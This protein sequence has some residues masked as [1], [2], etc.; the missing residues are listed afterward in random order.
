MKKKLLLYFVLLACGINSQTY[1]WAM[2]ETNDRSGGIDIAYDAQGNIFVSEL[3]SFYEHIAINKYD[4]DHNFLW[5]KTILSRQK[6]MEGGKIAADP[7]GNCYVTINCWDTIWIS[8]TMYYPPG[9]ASYGASYMIKYDP[10]GMVQWVKRITIY[11]MGLNDII[12]DDNGFIYLAGGGTNGWVD[13][14]KITSALTQ[15]IAKYSPAGILLRFTKITGGVTGFG[16]LQKD[17]QNNLYVYSSFYNWA[18]FDNLMIN[19]SDAVQSD[20]YLAKIDVNGNWLWAKSI[21]GSDGSGQELA[22]GLI[23]DNS[24]NVYVSGSM[25]SETAFFGTVTVQNTGA[26]DWFLAKFTSSGDCLWAKCGGGPGS[27]GA[28]QLCELNN[29]IYMARTGT[30][31]SK[32]DSD[33]NYLFS[34]FKP[35]VNNAAMVKDGQGGIYFTGSITD[36]VSFGNYLLSFTPSHSYQMYIA[37]LYD[38]SGF[39]LIKESIIDNDFEIYPN[40]AENLITVRCNEITKNCLLKITNAFGQLVYT[41][42]IIEAGSLEKKINTSHLAKGLYV[43]EVVNTSNKDIVR[44]K[45]LVIQ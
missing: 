25:G 1:S 18:K 19:A 22:G 12:T 29:K 39:T 34:D 37:R 43:I 36:T 7:Y 32:F 9:G 11:E 27:Q 28:G 15:F 6:H 42:T 45:K 40:P 41:E 44:A 4:A 3:Y 17:V 26:D 21:G 2:A 30:F 33:G 10:T 14:I 38:T 24:G 35:G 16:G 20:V 5:T 31:F 13:T 8:G 23:C